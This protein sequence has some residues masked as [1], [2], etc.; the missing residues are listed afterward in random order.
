M[1]LQTVPLYLEATVVLGATGS[2]TDPVTVYASTDPGH[3]ATREI[4]MLPGRG[5]LLTAAWYTAIEGLD[6]MP[7]MTR[8]DAQ[9]VGSTDRALVQVVASAKPG[10]SGSIRI[11]ITAL[12]QTTV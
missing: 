6:N 11:R 3:P 8:L 9:V 1:P 4:A 12:N 5:F 2:P 7:S 10:V